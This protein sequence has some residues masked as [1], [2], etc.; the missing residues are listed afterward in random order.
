MILL[1]RH[2]AT[3]AQLAAIEQ[4]V[5]ELGL[6]LVPLD[7]EKGRAFEVE[8]E[9]LGGML[10]LRHSPGVAEILTRRRSLTG[11]EPVWPHFALR[12]G[13]LSLVLLALLVLLAAYVPVGLADVAGT[14]G[15]PVAVEW[16]LRPLAGFLDLLPRGLPWLGGL[17][18]LAFWVGLFAWPFLDRALGAKRAV[19]L[20][21]VLGVAMILLAAALA[22]RSA[23]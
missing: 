15:D 18:L 21:R 6:R 23:P 7:G 19:L 3:A 4:R 14:P 17:L 16:Y 5:S 11:G 10:E 9:R 1:V 20:V 8:G 12:I 2:D 22:L 13:A